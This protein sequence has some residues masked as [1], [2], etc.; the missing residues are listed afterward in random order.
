MGSSW[1]YDWPG[2]VRDTVVGGLEETK[3]KE[4]MNR[5]DGVSQLRCQNFLRIFFNGSQVRSESRIP[6]PSHP[7][8]FEDLHVAGGQLRPT[9]LTPCWNW[10]ANKSAPHPAITPLPLGNATGLE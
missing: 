9:V 8:P 7:A 4:K 10:D 2:L 6:I 5:F 3:Y 1:S